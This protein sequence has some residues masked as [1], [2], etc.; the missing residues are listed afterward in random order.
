MLA[1]CERK[2]YKVTMKSLEAR[3]SR[4]ITERNIARSREALES[5]PR[6]MQALH[7]TIPDSLKRLSEPKVGFLAVVA[8][9]DGI[10]VQFAHDIPLERLGHRFLF[11]DDDGIRYH[12]FTKWSYSRLDVAPFELLGAD[13][14][15]GSRL[16]FN[17]LGS[18]VPHLRV[19]ASEHWAEPHIVM[20]EAVLANV[21]A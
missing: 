5:F 2:V 7:V 4:G 6:D 1:V 17:A 13:R 11:G 16:A 3:L 12:G 21:R 19:L 14:I 8:L 18:I 10:A 20:E 15:T 9:K